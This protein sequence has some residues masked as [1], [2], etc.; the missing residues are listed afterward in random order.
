MRQRVHA[1]D[2]SR[3]PLGPIESWP[4]ALRTLVD[5]ILG[6]AFP[7]VVL[8]GAELTQLYN[9]AYAEVI[10][11]KHPTALGMATRD[12]WPEAWEINEP[13]YA[14][15]RSGETVCFQ[16][17]RFVL[18]RHGTPDEAYF[19]AS[20]G[21][22]HGDDDAVDGILVTLFETTLGVHTQEMQAD[23]DRL[24][25]ELQV[26]RMRLEDVFR[27]A[28]TFLA[29]LRGPDHYFHLVND[30]YLQLVGHRDLIGRRLADA[31]PEVVKQGFIPIL[32]SV[33]A[34]GKPF[35]GREVPVMLQRTAG[36]A[37][38]QHFV[39]FV[40]QPLLDA[41]GSRIGIAAHG[42]DVTDQVVAR[43]EVEQV[44][45]QL[46]ESAA[47]LRASEQRLR[48]LFTQAPAAVAVL[49][50]P[51][52]VYTIASPRYL[53]TPGMGRSLLGRSIAEVFPELVG[54][55]F[56]ETMDRVY[57]T[58]E[59]YFANEQLV[60]LGRHGD[61]VLEDHYFNVGYQPLRDAT[62]AVYALA[63]VAYEVTDQMRARRELE[64]AKQAAEDARVE[65]VTASQ[66]KSAFLTTMSHE[67]RTPL[68]AVAGYSDLLLMG[69]RGPLSDGQRE[70]LERIKRSGQ[71]LLGLINDV[72]NFAK[73]DAG[74]VEYRFEDVRVAPLLDAL[75]VLIHPQVDA[76][77][78]R[79]EHGRCGADLA[80]R[81]DPE[82]TR[83]I[84]LNLL[85][86]AVKFTDA[87]GEVSLVCTPDADVVHLTVRDSGRG[88]SAD[89]LERVFDP[90]VQ[91]DRHLTPMSQQGVGLGLAISRDLA[92]GMGGSLEATSEPQ[93][94]SEFTLTLPRV[95]AR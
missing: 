80:V 3:T 66:A 87:G 29:V 12:C 59:P 61:G 89:R 17:A 28:P 48:D 67:L 26:E 34:T 93:R 18:E 20:Y 74:Q 31:L 43:R 47:E 27:Q 52:H 46:E 44:N 65:A 7:M 33:L 49:T 50:G 21:P 91:V 5:L 4:P 58:G 75:E 85:A 22:I 6:S 39:D 82:K 45:R 40:Y 30:A 57:R 35:I 19:T 41:D 68:N 38:E 86:N 8:W 78:L 81:A 42:S 23:R 53:E 90:F 55:G 64:L 72:L 32:D 14:R 9:D 83:Q 37:L 94:G 79:Y 10:G 36:P 62:G 70:D 77:G 71:Y 73:L 60:Q 95:K 11:E 15:V 1:L 56:I 25:R 84:L 92:I 63:S 51:D 54:Q 24:M 2:W 76:K 88:I 13:L 16:D 69:V